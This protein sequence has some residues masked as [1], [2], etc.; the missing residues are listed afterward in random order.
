MLSNIV[1]TAFDKTYLRQQFD[2]GSPLLNDYLQKQVSQDIKRR[3][4]SCFTVIDEDKQILGYYTLSS[5][6][7]PLV[8]LPENIK[9]KLPRYPS[10][11]AVL[12]GRLAVDKRVK[13]HGLG[14]ALLGNALKRIMRSDI[15]VYAVIVEAKDQS[16]VDFY[17]QFGF[18]TFPN[19]TK[20][21]FFPLG[22][23]I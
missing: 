10:V 12:L 6:S 9:Q 18:I 2:C 17:R 19:E 15:G 16:A 3:I 13:G 23:L 20:K 22:T 8:D 11:P 4:T 7:I 14:K 21:L 5:S 1:I